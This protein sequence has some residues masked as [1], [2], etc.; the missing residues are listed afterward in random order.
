M[1]S[2]GISRR[3]ASP[4]FVVRWWEARKPRFAIT[5]SIAGSPTVS[6]E[7]GQQFLDRFHR[8]FRWSLSPDSRRM[9]ARSD[10]SSG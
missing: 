1:L 3:I 5:P 8:G 7:Q 9:A 2:I 4:I 6:R 10:S